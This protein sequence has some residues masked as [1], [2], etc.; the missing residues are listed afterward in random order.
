MGIEKYRYLF[1]NNRYLYRY[2]FMNNRCLILNYRYLLTNNRGLFMNYSGKKGLHAVTTYAGNITTFHLPWWRWQMVPSHQDVIQQDQT[3][4]Q[5][6]RRLQKQNR[7]LCESLRC[8]QSP[9]KKPNKP[10][11]L[12]YSINGK[13]W[14]PK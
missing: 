7:F 8:Q 10:R 13:L 14:A 12:S 4:H 3:A 2:L 9:A 6:K 5:G 11:L 1:T